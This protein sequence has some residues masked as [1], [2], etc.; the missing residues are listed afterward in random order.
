MT[1]QKFFENNY[2]SK[3]IKALLRNTYLPNFP[4]I[5]EGY[6]MLSGKCYLYGNTILKCTDSGIFSPSGFYKSS[7]NVLLLPDTNRSVNGEFGT[8]FTTFSNSTENTIGIIGSVIPSTNVDI[9]GVSLSAGT[10]TLYSPNLSGLDGI[11]IYLE[12]IS[13]GKPI[14]KAR[15]SSNYSKQ[16]SFTLDRDSTLTLGIYTTYGIGLEPYVHSVTLSFDVMVYSGGIETPPPLFEPYAEPA[17]SFEIISSYIFGE[18]DTKLSNNFVSVNSYYDPETHVR[19]GE[20]LRCYRDIYGIDLMS[21]Y[22]CFAYQLATGFHVGKTEEGYSIINSSDENYKI[23][24]VPIKFNRTYTIAVD[25]SVPYI[26]YPVFYNRGGLVK[27]SIGET[28]KYLA[29]VFIPSNIIAK[30]CSMFNSPYKVEIKCPSDNDDYNKVDYS[31]YENS[32]YLVLQLPSDNKSSITVLEGD[33]TS[34]NSYYNADGVLTVPSVIKSDFDKLPT[35]EL[36]STMLCQIGLLQVNDG[37]IYAFSNKLMEYLLKNAIDPTDEIPQ[38]I[39]RIQERTNSLSDKTTIPSIFD[40]YM[41][42]K[43]FNK[44]IGTVGNRRV[45]INGYVD[46]DTEKFIYTDTAKWGD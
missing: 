10:Y 41:R 3:F 24:M 7:R 5:S 30:K 12:D 19:L 11:D 26:A 39:Y 43:I 1:F 34:K 38:N 23:V 15:L 13:N 4:T 37:N 25:C 27:T 36:N 6:Y 2:S 32:L 46:R 14:E 18:R 22:N 20:Y 29:S 9:V 35:K 44:Y 8:S 16:V 17:A 45:D 28:Y 40:Q 31:K 33:Y 21:L 42:S